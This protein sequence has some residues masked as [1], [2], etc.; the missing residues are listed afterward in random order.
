MN[1]FKISSCLLEF[2]EVLMDE[3]DKNIKFHSKEGKLLHRH[4]NR[5]ER[6]MLSLDYF[7]DKEFLMITNRI[8][9][10]EYLSNQMDKIIE[11]R[12]K[13]SPILLNKKKYQFI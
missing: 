7:H 3:R 12:L 13:S 5:I 1:Y 8:T 9:H 4:C 2:E 6:I 10:Q 11:R